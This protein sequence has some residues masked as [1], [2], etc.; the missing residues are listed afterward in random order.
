[1]KNKIINGDCLEVMKSIKE[2]SIDTILTDPPYDLT[3]IVK[4]FGKKGSAPA[5]YGKDGSF[6]RLSKGFMGK[7]WDGT[8]IAFKKETW[9]EALRVA[10]PGATLMAF[11]GT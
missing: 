2:N 3:S 1:M 11:G 5:Q 9:E 6:S 4:R 7:T 10:K 8:G